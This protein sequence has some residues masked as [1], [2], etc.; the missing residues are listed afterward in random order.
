M[1]RIIFCLPGDKFSSQFLISWTN[2][3]KA[4]LDAGH[5]IAIAPGVSSHVAFARAKTLGYNVLSGPNQKPFQGQ[6][7]YDVIMMIDSDIVFTPEHFFT[8]LESPHDVTSGMY[9]MSDN[10]H[11][12]CVQNWDEDY[13]A[14]NGTFQ[15]LTPGAIAEF[16]A[17]NPGTNYI[18]AHYSGLGWT[19]FKKGVLERLSYPPFFRPLENI[20]TGKPDMPAIVDMSSE[21]VCLFKNLADAGVQCF[22]DTR[23]R[24]G[25]EKT[26]VV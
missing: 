3:M 13:F 15:F 5:T 1:T 16:R 7:P 18:Q 20:P 21:D 9:I 25:H 8:L 19:M 10:K 26:F 4:C 22:L 24:V 14:K 2:L 17:T 11:F 23:V 6:I 12:A